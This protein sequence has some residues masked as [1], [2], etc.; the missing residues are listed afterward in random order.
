MLKPLKKSGLKLKTSSAISTRSF[1][2]KNQ[3][4]I[5]ENIILEVAKEPAHAN[6]IQMLVNNGGEKQIEVLC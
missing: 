6:S 3:Q 1:E 2:L 5:Y 4:L